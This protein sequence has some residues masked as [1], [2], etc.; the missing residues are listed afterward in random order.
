MNAWFTSPEFDYAVADCSRTVSRWVKAEES[1]QWRR[2]LLLVKNPD[3]L[4]VWD[5]ISSPMSS[6]WYL[7]TTGEKLIWGKDLITSKTAYNADLDIHVLSPSDPLVPN[8]TEGIFGA[9]GQR[10]APYPFD[11]LKYFSIPAKADEDILTVL[12]PRKPDG[13]PITTTLVSKS[14]EKVTLNV[15]HGNSTDLITIGKDGASFQRDNSPAIT[16]PMAIREP[17]KPTAKPDSSVT[18]ATSP[19]PSASPTATPSAS[20]SKVL[21]GTLIKDCQKDLLVDGK[22]IGLAKLPVG[23]KITIVSKLPDKYLVIREQGETPFKISKDSLH[24]DN[25]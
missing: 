15:T 22:K 18:S 21:T 25:P 19:S 13:A 7:H 16:I 17:V 2:H 3:Y 14:K 5:E 20:P 10:E 11:T 6:E 9:K 1:F 24:V 8:E 12:H 4:V 23:T